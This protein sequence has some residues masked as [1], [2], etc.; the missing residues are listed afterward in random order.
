MI[1]CLIVDSRSREKVLR[2]GFVAQR[3]GG[4][5]GN[6]GEEHACQLGALGIRKLVRADAE[7]RQRIFQTVDGNRIGNIQQ[8][9]SGA[10]QQRVVDPINALGI[11]D[12]LGR[13]WGERK[14]AGLEGK[15]K[16]NLSL[17][18]D[19]LEAA[20]HDTVK[21]YRRYARPRRPGFSLRARRSGLS[22]GSHRPG[23]SLRARR[24]LAAAAAESVLILIHFILSFLHIIVLLFYAG[25]RWLC[26]GK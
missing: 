7:K 6:P 13:V 25:N 11:Y 14:V 2:G 24:T 10:N 15:Q 16:M 9:G 5:R 12:N 4:T 18:R 17:R 8:F 22:L 1:D 26:T 20:L 21:V 23:F 3:D 19:R